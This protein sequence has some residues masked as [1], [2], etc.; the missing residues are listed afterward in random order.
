VPA[1]SAATLVRAGIVALSDC[2]PVTF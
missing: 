2:V 1:S